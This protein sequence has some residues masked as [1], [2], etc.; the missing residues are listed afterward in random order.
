EAVI[1]DLLPDFL[2]NRGIAYTSIGKDWGKDYEFDFVVE[3]EDTIYIGE[4]KKGE[5]NAAREI[6]KIETVTR[7]E[8]FY[9]NKPVHYI[10]IADRFSNKTEKENI[11]HITTKEFFT[12]PRGARD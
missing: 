10:L 6:E 9:K 4:I 5:L 3:G 8:P 11:L 2:K 7:K 12:P 1:I